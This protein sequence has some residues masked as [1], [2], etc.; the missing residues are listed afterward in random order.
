[1]RGKTETPDQWV[2][3]L[4]A[5]NDPA[6]LEA[7][8]ASV[9]MPVSA[10]A[11]GNVKRLR[12]NLSEHLEKNP[13][14]GLKQKAAK[15]IPLPKE[16]EGVP[17]GLFRKK[18]EAPEAFTTRVSDFV[19]AHGEAALPTLKALA[20]HMGMTEG[21]DYEANASADG[22]VDEIDHY[23]QNEN[24]EAGFKERAN[25][26]QFGIKDPAE[27]ARRT[28]VEG[29]LQH[30]LSADTIKER[31]PELGGSVDAML[32]EE[33]KGEIEPLQVQSRDTPNISHRDMRALTTADLAV[34]PKSP[35]ATDPQELDQA[36]KEKQARHEAMRARIGDAASRRMDEKVKAHIA[37]NREA[38]KRSLEQ[39]HPKSWPPSPTAWA[40]AC[41]QTPRQVSRPTPC[42]TR[43]RRKQSR[44][45]VAAPKTAGKSRKRQ[46]RRTQP[47]KERRRR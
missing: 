1:M 45:I 2:D 13:A 31:F 4:A 26:N 47:R 24:P 5:T 18:D 19:D 20:G 12:N 37:A 43:R 15:A 10:L 17:K 9:G 29:M 16:G 39:D 8:A 25:A 42:W 22:L 28:R 32:Q 44:F 27:V 14:A 41:H 7:A 6:V 3:R 36:A 46:G 40:S 30:G 23:V 38:S 34:A 33:K 21:E 35:A 11:K